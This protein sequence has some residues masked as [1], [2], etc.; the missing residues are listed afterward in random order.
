[1]PPGASRQVGGDVRD[2]VTRL[3][4]RHRVLTSL[5]RRQQTPRH[6][7]LEQMQHRQNL[8]ELQRHLKLQHPAD[9]AGILDSLPGDDRLLVFRQLEPGHAGAVLV[10]ANESVRASLVEDL[11]RDELVR[12]LR[13]L[14]ADDLAFVSGRFPKM[15]LKKRPPRWRRRRD[16]GSGTPE[17]LTRTQSAAS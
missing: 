11:D 7:L 12:T 15:C 14:D 17:I 6:D 5:A 2:E 9:I 13:T 3:L 16:P 1:M 4:E 10:E 8:V